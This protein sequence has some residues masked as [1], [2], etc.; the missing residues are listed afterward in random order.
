[1]TRSL[2]PAR[3]L[4]ALVKTTGALGI[5]RFDSSAWS[6]EVQAD[7]DELADPRP[8]HAQ[9]ERPVHEGQRPRIQV[10]EAGETKPNRNMHGG[11]Q[12]CRH[13]T[14]VVRRAAVI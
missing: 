2:G 8:R 14:V 10:R 11:G 4:I 1:M 12:V 13:Q 5:G 3:E 9:A 6:T 7:G